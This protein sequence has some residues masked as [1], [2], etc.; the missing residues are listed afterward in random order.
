MNQGKHIN[1]SQLK[2]FGYRE[3]APGVWSKDDS[4]NIPARSSA[5]IVEPDTRRKAKGPAK[6][7]TGRKVSHAEGTRYRLVVTSY[8]TT[9]I[10]PSNPYYKAIEDTLTKNGVFPDD[11]AEFCDQP[12]FIQYK[13]A[14]GLERTDVEVMSYKQQAPEKNQ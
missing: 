13:V 8:R 14:K 1:E 6:K 10:D 11:S 3:V 7:K 4:E 2:Q 12:L 9:L 5:S